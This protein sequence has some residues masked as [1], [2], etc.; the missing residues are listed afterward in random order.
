MMPARRASS[1]R[2][3]P[4]LYVTLATDPVS[5][6]PLPYSFFTGVQPSPA[7][8]SPNRPGSP[9]RPVRGFPPSSARRGA[10]TWLACSAARDE[11]KATAHRESSCPEWFEDNGHSIGSTR[12]VRMNR[13]H[14]GVQA[15]ERIIRWL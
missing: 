2:L 11:R 7:P 5:V 3:D 10:A 9:S 12:L 14:D 6:S 8:A 4:A 13:V 1:D 15:Q